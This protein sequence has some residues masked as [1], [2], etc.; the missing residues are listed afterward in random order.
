[1]RT[2]DNIILIIPNS[3]FVENNVTNWSHGDPTVRLHA[4]V[5]VA[6]GSD[7]DTVKE[8]LLK[9][10]R[11]HPKVLDHPRPEVRFLGF[12]DSS[13]DLDLLIWTDVPHEQFSITSEIF[14]AI[15]AG[16]REAGVTIPFPQRDVHV[17]TP[18][19]L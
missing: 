13:L 18:Q 12:G 2:L 9:V 16:F 7:L 15:D 4:P 8:T 10:A 3:Q 14:Y 1:M 11:E 19:G 6:Y 5:G 17:K